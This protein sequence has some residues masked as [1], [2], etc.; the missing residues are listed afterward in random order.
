M[1]WISFS[2]YAAA[3]LILAQQRDEE[4]GPLLARHNHDF[5]RSYARWFEAL[6]LDKYEYIGEFD[7]MRLAFLMDV[8]LYYLGVASQPFKRGHKALTEPIFST[9]PSVPFFHF[10]RTYN[11]RFAQISRVRRKRKVSGRSN[12][13]RR[14]MFAGYTFAL[15]S[16][17]PIGKA[18]ASWAWLELTEGWRSWFGSRTRSSGAQPS[19]LPPQMMDVPA[20]IAHNPSGNS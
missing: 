13:H 2:S 19:V 8:G 3:R 10:I 5:S 6:Y 9:P 12:D 4:L 15:G 1:D 7:L 20:E 18:I 17:A 16:A 14:F 11:R